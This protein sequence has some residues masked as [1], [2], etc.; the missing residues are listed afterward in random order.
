MDE[1]N[2]FDKACRYLA[3]RQPAGLFAWLLPGHEQL[4]A[5]DDW[6][7]TRRL[8]FPGEP[9]RTCD[10]VARFRDRTEPGRFWL[11]VLE[12]QSHPERWMLLRLLRYQGA[13]LWEF[14]PP[15][16][17]GQLPSVGGVLVNLTGRSRRRRFDM[18]LATNPDVSH[19]FGVEVRNLAGDSAAQTLQ[20]IATGRLQR[21]V[22]PW[23]P[24]MHGGAES[25]MI[26]EWLRVVAEEPDESLRREYAG[27]AVVFAGLAG[28]RP[29]WERAVEDSGMHDKW[30]RSEV[31][32]EMRVEGE[33]RARRADL[34]ELLQIRFDAVPE[35]IAAAV[36]EMTDRVRL[37]RWFRH[38]AKAKSLE[39]F[40]AAVRVPTAN[41]PHT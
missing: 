1:I 9:D 22:L 26:R 38:A 21:C 32:E 14:R 5:F 20:A 13:L 41:G 29:L 19:R 30:K 39:S 17:R 10:T 11:L 12:F 4:L 28:C 36:A 16:R 25:G 40:R 7:D 31:M 27:L 24:L 6:V 37:A 33:I 15:G 18:V 35:D 2:D 8:P 3:K 23:I 34:L